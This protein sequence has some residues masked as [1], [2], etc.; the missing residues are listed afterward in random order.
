MIAIVA[1][2][3]ALSYTKSWSTSQG[4]APSPTPS[5]YRWCR[6]GRAAARPRNLP[7][8]QLVVVDRHSIGPHEA[9]A[10]SRCSSVPYPATLATIRCPL[11]LRIR[12]RP[13]AMENPT[14]STV[15][16]VAGGLKAGACRGAGVRSSNAA[17]EA[18]FLSR[19]ERL[20][21]A[22]LNFS[23]SGPDRRN[24][25]IRPKTRRSR[26]CPDLSALCGPVD[27]WATR[28]GKAVCSMGAAETDRRVSLS[29]NG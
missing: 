15:S 22:C 24:G 3:A 27:R 7:V 26:P 20:L 17:A 11:E 10:R 4:S 14:V 8:D 1:V 29:C 28:W 13:E 25:G 6:A 5:A 9:G 23:S 21:S 19:L 18:Q 2:P 12:T 16:R